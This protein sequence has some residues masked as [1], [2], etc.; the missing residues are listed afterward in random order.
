LNSSSTHDEKNMKL[1]SKLEKDKIN[2]KVM[3]QAT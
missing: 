3:A 1:F 2:Q